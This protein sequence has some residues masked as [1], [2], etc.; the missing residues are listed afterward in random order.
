M[1]NFEFSNDM[2][3][4]LSLLVARRLQVRATQSH[5]KQKTK[6]K[7]ANNWALYR[8]RKTYSEKRR[9]IA[10]QLVLQNHSELCPRPKGAHIVEA[11]LL[12]IHGSACEQANSRSSKSRSI[13]DQEDYQ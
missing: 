4:H 7:I 8:N 6:G 2:I 10:I 5:G 12:M 1:E 3:Q 11:D 9:P 13:P